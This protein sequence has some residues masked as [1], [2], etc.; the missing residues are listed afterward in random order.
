MRGPGRYFLMRE[1]ASLLTVAKVGMSAME[2][3]TRVKT[4]P[5]VKSRRL[6]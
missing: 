5:E 3:G 2:G 6:M 4:L 1:L